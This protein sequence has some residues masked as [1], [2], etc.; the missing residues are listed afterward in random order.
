MKRM[1]RILLAALTAAMFVTSAAQAAVD[2]KTFD[3]RS[4]PTPPL[5][6]IPAV[7]PE[8]VQFANGAVVYLL[9][10][11]ALPTDR[12]STRLNSSHRT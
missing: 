5:G 8:R 12:K 3:P 1:P 7:T 9:E 2:P 4:L 10:D 6:R 11:H